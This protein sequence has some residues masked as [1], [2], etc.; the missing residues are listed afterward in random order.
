MDEDQIRRLLLCQEIGLLI[1]YKGI[2]GWRQ[3]H[4]IHKK[5]EDGECRAFLS[6]A[7]THPIDLYACT[8]IDILVTPSPVDW[9]N[10]LEEG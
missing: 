1:W 2:D 8:S 4:G 9:N 3:I 5:E 6:E 7:N 10:G